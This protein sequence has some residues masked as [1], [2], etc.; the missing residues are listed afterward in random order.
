LTIRV[1]ERAMKIAPVV[2]DG[3]SAAKA[4]PARARKAAAGAAAGA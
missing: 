2:A 3:E 4:R 1:A